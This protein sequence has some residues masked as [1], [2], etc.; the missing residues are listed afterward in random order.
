M[1]ILNF[2]SIIEDFPGGPVVRLHLPMQRAQVQS[3]VK[4]LNPLCLAAQKPKQN[5][6]N[7]ITNSIKTLKMVHLKKKNLKK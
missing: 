4:V 7:S 6:S 3:L 1:V 5:R 2:L